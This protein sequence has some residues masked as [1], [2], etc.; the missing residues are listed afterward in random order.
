MW[1]LH[2]TRPQA[3]TGR[4]QEDTLVTTQREYLT[5]AQ[6][7]KLVRVALGAAFPGEMFSVRSK[8]YSGGAS[9]D[10]RWTDGSQT[11]D[12]ERVAK[13]YEGA[14][15]DGMIDLKTYTSH[16][17][18]PDGTVYVHHAAGTEG[19]RG[20]IPAEDNRALAELMPA[21]V[22]VV[23]F[24]ADFVFCSRDVSD[25]DTKRAAALDWLYANVVIDRAAPGLRH[26]ADRVG[27]YWVSDIATGMTQ[28]WMPGE[29]LATTYDRFWHRRD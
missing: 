14:D 17:L 26:N 27:G 9:I 16:Y 23:H 3:P 28:L 4:P 11:K 18:R 29:D 19:S 21:G 7:A 5:A 24:C 13:Q 25:Y 1:C 6:T 22:R 12:V 2:Q 15:F 8:T 20:V 10:V